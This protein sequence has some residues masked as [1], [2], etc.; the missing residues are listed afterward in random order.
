MPLLRPSSG[1]QQW[2]DTVL[3]STWTTRGGAEAWASLM[4]CF[5]GV[6]MAS[7]RLLLSCNACHGQSNHRTQFG[8]VLLH[9]IG[10]CLALL[11]LFD[12]ALHEH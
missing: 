4:Y 1:G 12:G 11:M 10:C 2:E 3:V 8:R 6:I 7:I 9:A 5:R